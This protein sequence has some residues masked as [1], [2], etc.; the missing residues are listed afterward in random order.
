MTRICQRIGHRGLNRIRSSASIHRVVRTIH[1]QDVVSVSSD[2]RVVS[3]STIETIIPGS[4]LQ[5]VPRGISDDGVVIRI[6]NTSDGCSSQ[7]QPLHAI[8]ATQRVINT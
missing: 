6:S 4:A 8:A 2:Q 1:N 3:T 7:N 5:P